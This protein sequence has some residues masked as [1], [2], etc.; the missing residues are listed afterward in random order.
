[1]KIWILLIDRSTKTNE[2]IQGRH[3]REFSGT[4]HIEIRT[5]TLLRERT[6][7]YPKP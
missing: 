2:A 4:V 1:M 7:S 5:T 3:V 6:H